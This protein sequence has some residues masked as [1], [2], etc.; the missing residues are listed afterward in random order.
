MGVGRGKFQCGDRDEEKYLIL[1]GLNFYNATHKIQ[2]FRL[3][4]P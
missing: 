4:D 2:Y 1:K 3:L